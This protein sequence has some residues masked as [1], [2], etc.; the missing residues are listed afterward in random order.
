MA[1]IWLRSYARRRLTSPNLARR[2]AAKQCVRPHL[3]RLED[4]CTPSV[5]LTVGAGD[6]DGG[7]PAVVLDGV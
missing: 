5:N 1:P 3:E 6:S 2:R 7:D 4:R